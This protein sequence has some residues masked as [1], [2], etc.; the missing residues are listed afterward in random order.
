MEI[1]AIFGVLV[2]FRCGHQR[3]I[4]KQ[5]LKD[6]LATVSEEILP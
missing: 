6:L 2:V 3:T 4:I 1:R 5:C